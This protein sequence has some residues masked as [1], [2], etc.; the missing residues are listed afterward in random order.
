[1]SPWWS[2]RVWQTWARAFA[3]WPAP[4]VTSHVFYF[5]SRLM[6]ESSAAL[7]PELG[8]SPSPRNM[9]KN[10]NA[11]TKVPPRSS[12]TGPAPTDS[13]TKTGWYTLHFVFK[14]FPILKKKVLK[15]LCL[16]FRFSALTQMFVFVYLIWHDVCRPRVMW[17]PKWLPIGGLVYYVGEIVYT[18]Q[19][20]FIGSR[21][22]FGMQ[23]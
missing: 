18:T 6:L 19:D 7:S 14:L 23:P 9:E 21:Q 2:I 5:L 15:N 11:N 3:A 4:L 16:Y 12:S 17:C 20:A 10:P 13:K 22:A 1:M 8:L